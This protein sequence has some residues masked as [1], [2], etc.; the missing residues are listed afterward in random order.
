M[1]QGLGFRLRGACYIDCPLYQG[2]QQQQPGMYWDAWVYVY[3][4][5][6][7]GLPL[8][9]QAR[10]N[11]ACYEQH[12]GQGSTPVQGQNGGGVAYACLGLVST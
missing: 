2:I 9:Q 5:G 3:L 12:L 6:P 7:M 4:Q 11:L 1:H 10:F 8:L